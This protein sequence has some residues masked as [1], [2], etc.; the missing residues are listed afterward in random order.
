MSSTSLEKLK[1]TIWAYF[2][3]YFV[4]LIALSVDIVKRTCD[5]CSMLQH[6]IE[7]YIAL[8]DCIVNPGVNAVLEQVKAVSGFLI[9]LLDKVDLRICKLKVSE[10]GLTLTDQ[11]IHQ[12]FPNPLPVINL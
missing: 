12:S 9:N 8:L 6:V 4:V 5:V 3:A 10:N 11:K 1:Q 7:K 2:A